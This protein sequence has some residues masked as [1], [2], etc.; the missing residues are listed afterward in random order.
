MADEQA[1]TKTAEE[2]GLENAEEKAEEVKQRANEFFK[3]NV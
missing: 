3:G 1:P 2:D